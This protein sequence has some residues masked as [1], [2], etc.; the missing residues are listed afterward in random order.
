VF[1]AA[2]TKHNVFAGPNDN[3]LKQVAEAQLFL[4]LLISVMLRTDLAGEAIGAQKQKQL[5]I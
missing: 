5:K 1:F 3:F 4:T 2:Q